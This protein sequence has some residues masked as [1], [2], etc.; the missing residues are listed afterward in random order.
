MGSRGK[1]TYT[2]CP[3]AEDGAHSSNVAP[4]ARGGIPHATNRGGLCLSACSTS[5]HSRCVNA[6]TLPPHSAHGRAAPPVHNASKY[7]MA[8][9]RPVSIRV[10]S[11]R[12]VPGT[13][14]NCSFISPFFLAS[15]TSPSSLRSLR[16]H[17]WCRWRTKQL[18]RPRVRQPRRKS[19]V[20]RACVQLPPRTPQSL[21]QPSTG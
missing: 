3:Y 4:C 16:S 1:R 15:I 11:T 14:F 7:A 5:A 10:L 17:L 2:L 9:P 6:C 20:Q 18:S 8:A 13:I 19:Y 21:A 12:C